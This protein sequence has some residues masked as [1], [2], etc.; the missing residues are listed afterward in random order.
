MV[1]AIEMVGITIRKDRVRMMTAP[2][3][4]ENDFNEKGLQGILVIS[5]LLISK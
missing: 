2:S 5:S 1:M 3:P 4:P